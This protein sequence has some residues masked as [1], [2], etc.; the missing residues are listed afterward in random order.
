MSVQKTDQQEMREKLKDAVINLKKAGILTK[1]WTEPD[2]KST[3]HQDKGFI[4]IDIES[5]AFLIKRSIM[6]PN[7]PMLVDVGVKDQYIVIEVSRQ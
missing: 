5:I 3:F 1:V 7:V 2:D 6:K 4:L